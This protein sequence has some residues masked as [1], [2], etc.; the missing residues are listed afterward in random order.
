MQT[1][2]LANT[3]A[4]A[5]GGG[6]GG[7]RGPPPPPMSFSLFCHTDIA[8]RLAL[9]PHWTGWVHRRRCSLRKERDKATTNNNSKTIRTINIGFQAGESE[10]KKKKNKERRKRAIHPANKN[11]SSSLCLRLK[12]A[13][14]AAAAPHT[15]TQ[16]SNF[17]AHHSKRCTHTLSLSLSLS[18]LAIFLSLGSF[19]A[20]LA[21][22]AKNQSKSPG[23]INKVN[24]PES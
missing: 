11:H 13:A 14:T 15:P 3:K 7:G 1:A 17:T 5:V 12:E 23:K 2:I 20:L 16:H 6:D 10:P 21:S 8:L 24:K 18:L 19:A 4:A 9:S 22:L